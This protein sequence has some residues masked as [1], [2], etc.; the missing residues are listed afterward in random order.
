MNLHRTQFKTLPALPRL[1]FIG[2]GQLAK[3]TGQATLQLG[4]ELIVLERAAHSPASRLANQVIVGGLE[5]AEALTALAKQS[6][7]IT[8]EN[9]FV[10]A[11]A[12]LVA[13]RAGTRV[14]PSPETMRRV[15]DKLIQKQTLA[16][17][18]LPLPRFQAVAS[19]ADI[20]RAGIEFGW[21]MVLKKRRNGY[22][23]KG[24]FTVRTEADIT[25]AWKTLDGDK[26]ELYAE[27]FCPYVAELAVIITRNERGEIA[28][29][30]VVESIQR[31]HICHVVKAPA[32]VSAAITQRAAGIARK[33]IETIEGVGS[34]GIELFLLANGEVLVN[35]LA[36]RVHNSGH[37]TIEACVCSQFEN[38]V[39]AVL[40]WPLGSTAMRA[41]AAVM[42][43]LLGAGPGPGGPRGLAEALAVTG[44]HIHIYGKA[45]SGAGRKMGHVTALGNTLAEAEA[46][47][48]RAAEAL[49][50]GTPHEK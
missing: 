25:P 4:C 23:G 12:L 27:A 50:F 45:E 20:R 41:P 31:N 21:P 17:A 18:G 29:Y 42:V 7:L 2:G 5:D 13:E 28:E 37:Y 6:D 19:E 9:E 15:Q 34:F 48:C 3:M 38:H 35:E 1:G 47:A 32:S 16:A 43:N 33:A 46:A 24:N 44:A 8:L 30:P 49:Q 36:P 40:G 26:N 39:R 10:G 14:W 22:D 11:D